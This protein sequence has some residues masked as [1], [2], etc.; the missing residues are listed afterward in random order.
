[1]A[2]AKEVKLIL[3]QT[4]DGVGNVKLVNENVKAVDERVKTMADG[5]QRLFIE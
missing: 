1:M 4:T 5:K 2:T 3:E